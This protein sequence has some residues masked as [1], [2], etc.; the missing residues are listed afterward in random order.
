MD[1]IDLTAKALRKKSKRREKKARQMKLKA[2][3]EA[4]AEAEAAKL[5]KNNNNTQKEAEV[6]NPED[7]NDPETTP[8]D[9]KKLSRQMA[10]TYK[11]SA[12]E[13][14][15]YEWWEKSKFFEADPDSSKP[16]FVI[17]L[18][19][20]NVTGPLHI[21]HALTAAIQDTIIRWRRMSG[22]NTLWVPG[23]DHAGIAAQA[24]VEKQFLRFTTIT[25]DEMGR[26]SF[27]N[28]L[29]DMKNLYRDAILRQLRCLGASLDWSRE[30]Y[31]MDE[32][33]SL[34]VT[35]AFV[36]LHKDGVIYRQLR[37]V[38]WDCLLQTAISNIEVE[39]IEIKERTPLRVPGYEKPVEFGVL[40]SFAYPLEEGLGEIIVATT[41]VETMLGDTAIAVHPDDSRYSHVHGKFAIHP[42]NGRKLPIVCDAVLVDM[43]FGTGA[44]KITP[45]HDPNDYEV[46]KRL[47][48]EIINIFT[49][50]GKINSNGGPE[51]TGM[52][53]FE[54]RV[55]VTEAL[56]K[57]GLFKGDQ[58][59]E[60]RLGICSR[61]RDVVEPLLKPQWYVN[62]KS[63]AEQALDAVTDGASPKIEIIPK[64]YV[65]EWK[66]WFENIPDWCISRQIGWGHRIPAWYAVLI[67]E[68]KEL[69]AYN[70]HWVV[71]RNKAEA[72]EEANKIFSGKEFD[73]H[74][75][76]DVLDTWFS[77]G[78]FPLSV[79]GWPNDTKD[80]RAFY[81]T[82]VLETG[83]DILFL[84]VARMVMLGM[85]LGGD[86][87]FRKVYLHPMVCDA[88]GREMSKLLGNAIDPLEV[89]NGIELKGLH[90]KL[91][92]E[93]SL[94]KNELEIAKEDYVK[95]F[96]DG[97]PECGADALRFALVSYTAQSDKIKLDIQKVVEYR[98][99]CNKLWDA[100]RFSMTKLGEDYIPREEMIPATLPFSCKWILS[101]LN[102]AIS[103]T[104]VSLDSYEFSDAATAVYSW[105]QFQLCDVFM[106]VIKPYFT[107]NDPAYASE[108][109]H[110][111]DTLWLCL[112]NG[113]RL[114]HP[115][116]PFVTEEL[117]QRLP[118]KKDSVRKES[119]VISEYPSTVESWNIDGVELE[120]DL[121]Q[122]V[123]KSLR[124]LRAQ[125]GPNEKCERLAA[126]VVCLTSDAW[127]TIKKHELEVSTL[128]TLSSLHV[129]SKK[130]DV[131][132]GC[133]LDTLNES[134]SVSVF[135]K[136]KGVVNVE[137]E[138]EKLNKKMEYLQKEYDDLKKISK[139]MEKLQKQH[140][141]LKNLV[142]RG[143]LQ[144]CSTDY[145]S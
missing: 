117:W 53:R 73:L 57:K 96:P 88:R 1:P 106:E 28:D 144:A 128:A 84:W 101:V 98:Q 20:P 142:T 24:Y 108:R 87:P 2:E 52:P 110:A 35:E 65:A 14:S 134:E 79:L 62:C 45:A 123:V 122:F 48:L 145:G 51:F 103:K 83:P 34:A 136:L 99:W 109:K 12:V 114:L 77:S 90:K 95:D 30:C 54:A 143:S 50:G 6:E 27:I 132:V 7:Y 16:S 102:K 92:D 69:G 55:A 37:L 129:L 5:Q 56:K 41:R 44:V 70:D 21:G 31:T 120:M 76:P 23:T 105:W 72:T 89:I 67:D 116:M 63:M 133:I 60:M 127:N 93:S 8:G 141:D 75:D 78:I 29:G 118:S 66:R 125:L 59:N 140:D 58:N 36:R 43:N 135:L 137:A 10:K 13:T 139:K 25:R 94:D 3:A 111:Q 86:V 42:F 17:V 11:P 97:I 46:G 39:H 68:P 104:I 4:E 9:K 126:F 33:R 80:L 18:P 26:Y 131:P 38:N 138:F 85:K 121:I 61:T 91:D 74:K 119:I 47:N 49:D 64:Q 71:G 19:P 100:I 124:S 112:D 15:W 22:Y 113:L 40:T 82:S 32:K 107:G 115:F 81:S 130:D